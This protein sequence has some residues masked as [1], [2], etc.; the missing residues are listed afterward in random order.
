VENYFYFSL[1]AYHMFRP[2]LCGLLALIMT[3]NAAERT[4]R[5]N[6]MEKTVE[7]A[8]RKRQQR[9]AIALFLT[10]RQS[11]NLPDIQNMVKAVELATEKLDATKLDDSFESRRG[12]NF[13]GTKQK[14][15]RVIDDIGFTTWKF[16]DHAEKLQQR[17]KN[18]NEVMEGI[19]SPCSKTF[20]IAINK[21]IQYIPRVEALNK[22]ISDEYPEVKNLIARVDSYIQMDQATREEWLSLC[23]GHTGHGCPNPLDPETWTKRD[24]RGELYEV[25]PHSSQ[26]NIVDLAVRIEL[27]LAL[28]WMFDNGAKV[29]QDYV[30]R[31]T[32]MRMEKGEFGSGWSYI[33]PERTQKKKE[34]IR[35][36]LV[37]GAD[38]KKEY[39]YYNGRGDR[40]FFGDWFTVARENHVPDDVF[41]MVQRGRENLERQDFLPGERGDR[42]FNEYKHRLDDQ[43]PN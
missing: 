37:G 31:N 2:T 12:Q 21:L 22:D 4:Q 39:I 38:P 1:S 20:S 42:D 33:S 30:G 26:A 24:F 34:V 29:S 40:I 10:I 28:K 27:P 23:T 19:Y 3:S 41:D 8:E 6:D 11:M 43:C 13:R 9:V 36:L 17:M 35:I 14:Y 15:N 7:A 5:D 32:L 16:A 18:I 25:T